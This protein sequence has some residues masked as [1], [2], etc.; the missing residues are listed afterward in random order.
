MQAS[1]MAL[2]LVLLAATASGRSV[3]EEAPKPSIVPIRAMTGH[4]E[5]LHGDPKAAGPFVLRIRELP[6]GVIAPH[7]HPV[8]EHITVVQGTL[9][10][11]VGE[12]FDRAATQKLVAGGYAFIPKGT[13]MFGYTPEAAILQVHGIGPFRIQWRAGKEVARPAAHARRRRRGRR[14][15]FPQ[16]RARRDAARRRS[17]S[18]GL[19]FGRLRRLRHRR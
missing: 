12:K 14:V 6:G 19:R 9:Y 3:A 11:G 13:T 17:H 4:V 5:V 15:P 16:G 1:N 7:R 18:A 8:D 10:F 2:A